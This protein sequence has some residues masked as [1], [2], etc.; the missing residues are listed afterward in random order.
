MYFNAFM[1]KIQFLI[2][3]ILK[4]VNITS[5]TLQSIFVSFLLGAYLIL[6]HSIECGCFTNSTEINAKSFDFYE[7]LLQIDDFLVPDETLKKNANET[8]L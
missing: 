1:R 6:N 3:L 7:K 4:L 2:Q 8:N 5:L